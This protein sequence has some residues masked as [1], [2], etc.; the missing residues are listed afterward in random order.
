MVAAR[1]SFACLD[2]GGLDTRFVDLVETRGEMW[3]NG[4]RRPLPPLLHL[5]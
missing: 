1:S 2:G 5:S 4:G 3:K